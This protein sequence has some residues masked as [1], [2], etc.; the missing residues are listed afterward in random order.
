MTSSLYDWEFGALDDT[1]SPELDASARSPERFILS[2]RNSCRLQKS[3]SPF[4]LPVWE[5]LGSLE[6][7]WEPPW[8]QTG[9]LRLQRW[10]HCLR[11]PR[12]NMVCRDES[13]SHIQRAGGSCG[14]GSQSCPSSISP[15]SLNQTWAPQTHPQLKQLLSWTHKNPSLYPFSPL[16]HALAPG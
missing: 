14:A 5:S 11:Y 9:G 1:V 13:A 2:D 3:P 10:V 4:F 8:P 7:I 15:V 16:S 12:C 6:S